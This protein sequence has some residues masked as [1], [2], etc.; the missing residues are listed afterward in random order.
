M[1]QYYKSRRAR[2]LFD[3]ADPV[4]FRLSRTK[5]DLFVE[6]PRCFY[7]DLRLG[8][9][10]PRGYPHTL[11][12]AVDTLLK[13]EFDVYRIKGDP[14]PLMRYYG[15]EAVPLRHKDIN[16][17]RDSR[18]GGIEHIHSPTNFRVTG[19]IDDVWVNP[20]G[21]LLVVDYKATAKNGE[22]GIDADWQVS[23]KRQMEIDQ[24]LFRR[25]GFRVSPTGYFVYV[26]GRTDAEAFDGRLEFDVNI[27]PYTGDDSWL[28]GTL[29]KARSCLES[30]TL[31]EFSSQCD[32]CA[33]AHARF[34]KES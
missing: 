24:W 15:I 7:L 6:C 14:H 17:W 21:E 5:I 27:I 28:E 4:P 29:K 32:Y 19:G 30:D 10:R 13:K 12:V 3:P 25:N 2:G 20:Q 23:Y 33:Y 8:I 11:N 16:L 34:E 9:A 26:N 31:P 1:S 18:R 22:V